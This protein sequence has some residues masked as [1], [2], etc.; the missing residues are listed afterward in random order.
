VPDA[1]D[2][3]VRGSYHAGGRATALLVAW[4]AIIICAAAAWYAGGGVLGVVA[5]AVAGALIV[6]YRRANPLRNWQTGRPWR[7]SARRP[8]AGPGREASSDPVEDWIRERSLYDRFDDR[9]AGGEDG[10]SRDGR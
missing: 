4:A 1:Y 10:A 9:Q 3:I 8:A 2:E 5:V 6:M 7:D